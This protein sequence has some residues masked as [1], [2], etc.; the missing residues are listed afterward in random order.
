[1]AHHITLLLKLIFIYGLDYV[2]EGL[3]SD[4]P[5]ALFYEGFYDEAVSFL[6]TMYILGYHLGS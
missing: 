2:V 1:M 5:R 3:I 4:Y 6:S